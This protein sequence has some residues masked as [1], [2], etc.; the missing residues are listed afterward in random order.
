MPGAFTLHGDYSNNPYYPDV[1]VCDD[2]LKPSPKYFNFAKSYN[3]SNNPYVPQMCYDHEKDF[4]SEIKQKYQDNVQKGESNTKIQDQ[5]TFTGLAKSLMS[6]SLRIN[7]DSYRLFPPEVETPLPPDYVSPITPR[8]LPFTDHDTL[9]N[10]DTDV[11]SRSINDIVNQN[12]T[13]NNINNNNLSP[14]INDLNLNE[15]PLKRFLAWN[16]ESLGCFGTLCTKPFAGE[17]HVS[18]LLQSRI[19][20]MKNKTFHVEIVSMETF[21]NDLKYLTG[22]INKILFEIVLLILNNIVIFHFSWHSIGYF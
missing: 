18:L 13:N 1:T 9:T 11:N 7:F 2:Y 10:N 22:K 12:Q 17:S 6:T 4:L 20:Q 19:N 14:P 5:C 21:I 15:K 3:G 16:W 8:A